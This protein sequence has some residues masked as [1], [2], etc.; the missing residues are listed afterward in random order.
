MALVS[1]G[2]DISIVDESQYPAA[3]T[4]TIPFILVATAQNKVEAGGTAVASGTLAS[5]A[6][7]TYLIS[8]QRELVNTFGNPF[9]YKTSAGS[10]LHGYELNEYGLQAAYSALGVSNRAYVQ[11]VDID[12]SE[13][14]STTTRPTG[15]PSDGT[16]WLDTTESVWGLFEW[17]KTT[18]TFTNKVPTVITKVADLVGTVSTG[19]PLTS[20]G[21]VG[22]YVVNATHT[23]N[24]MYYK[25]RSNTW[26][27]LGSD[28]WMNSHATASGT[29]GATTTASDEFSINGTTVTLTG[30]TVAQA[31]IDITTA[32][33][34]GITA[35]EVSGALEIYADTT[36]T[37]SAAVLTEV[38]NTPLNDLGITAATYASPALAQ[39]AHTSNPQ[40]RTTDT[41]PRPNGS[42][43]HKTTSVN[44]GANLSLK[45][46]S[47]AIAAF[48]AVS[49]PVYEN[50]QTANKEIDPSAGGSQI[51]V[52][53]AYAMFDSSENDTGSVR[54]FRRNTTGATEVTGTLTSPTLTA[55]D[56]YTISASAKGVTTM[57]TAVTVTLSGATA[58]DFVSDFLAANVANTSASVT[59]TGAVKI[60][61]TQGG[62]IVLKDTT[63]TPVTDVG[64]LTTISNVRAG[65]D[66]DVIL[67]NWE[68]VFDTTG[69]TADENE[70]NLNPTTGTKWFFADVDD[71][72]IMM[73]DGTNWKGYTNVSN[74][75]RGFDLSTTDPAGPQTSP[76]APTTQS[77]D[78]VLVYGDLWI[79]SSDLDNYPKVNRWESVS[80]VDQWVAIDTADQTT[81][82][83]IVFADARWGDSGDVDPITDD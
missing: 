60:T 63:G 46:Y 77:D 7:N 81:E 4:A 54:F 71:I 58:A 67:S 41:T 51:S 24:P 11:R 23:N 59:S 31:V 69:F 36:A 45:R 66:T 29:S 2:V 28:A 13:L 79:D 50:D 35:A 83:G 17:N 5:A 10:S 6:N 42:V 38:T 80:G 48:D 82:D 32:A 55:T 34:T 3:T 56:Q 62:V 44:L 9:F 74:D 57:T 12:M 27:L 40:W 19:A 39:A 43:W 8:S 68:S 22:D 78:T 64:I 21:N 33:I 53:T 49:M 16:Y 20:I 18:A 75:V 14:T 37:N 15:S 73:H 70:P 25:N 26:V 30:T 65:N 76:T 47:T 52:G 1:P 61:H 72:D